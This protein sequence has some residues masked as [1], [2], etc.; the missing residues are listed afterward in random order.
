[1]NR[2]WTLYVNY[3]NGLSRSNFFNDDHDCPKDTVVNVIERSAIDDYVKRIKELEEAIE[4]VL[5]ARLGG[6]ITTC[7]IGGGD[8][9]GKILLDKLST[10]LHSKVPY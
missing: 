1:M 8:D 7:R 4:Y 2:T 3:E 9:A 10:V 5:H 6:H